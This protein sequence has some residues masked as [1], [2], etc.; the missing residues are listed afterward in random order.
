LTA[1]GLG[2]SD[3]ATSL[4]RKLLPII[5]SGKRATSYHS[6]SGAEPLEPEV[7]RSAQL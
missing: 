6:P 2:T 4:N 7:Q 5:A 3:F 1:I